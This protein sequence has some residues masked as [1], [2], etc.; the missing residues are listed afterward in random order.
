LDGL[1][2]YTEIIG[3]DT[4]EHGVEAFAESLKGR[5][6]IRFQV[7][8]ALRLYFNDSSF[9]VVCI[10]N[11]HQHHDPLVVI[12]EIYLLKMILTPPSQR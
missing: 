8:D 7:M 10:S 5:P 1:K 4:S 6:N 11:S 3:V 2:D 12:R 9:D